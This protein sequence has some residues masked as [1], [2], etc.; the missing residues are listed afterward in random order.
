[1]LLDEKLRAAEEALAIAAGAMVDALAERETAVAGESVAVTVSAWN[2]G[3]RPLEVRKVELVTP[4]SWRV[5]E[6]AGLSKTI[7]PGKLEEWKL[8]AAPPADAPPTVPYFLR[9]PLKG[10]IYDWSDAPP[11]ARG[12]P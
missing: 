3:G 7:E 1:M 5:P 9:H 2:A 11:S 6:A 12:E 4:A 8:S 10:A